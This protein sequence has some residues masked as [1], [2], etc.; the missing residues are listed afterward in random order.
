MIKGLLIDFGGTIDTDGIHWFRMFQMAYAQCGYDIPEDVLRQAYVYAERT[1]GKV[2]M[3]SPDM[4]MT[5][6]IRVK[7]GLQAGF[8]RGMGILLK[9]CC[10]GTGGVPCESCNQVHEIE[11]ILDCCMSK[12][13]YNIDNVSAPVLKELSS[14]YRLGLVSNF[15][16]NINAVLAEFGIDG[17]FSSVTESAVVG[18]RKPD[19]EIFRIAASSL[20]LTPAEC[21]A[22]GDS[23]DKD[24]IPAQTAGCR[25]VWLTAPAGGGAGVGAAGGG[26]GAGAGVAGGGAS[27]GWDAAECAPDW[28]I[29][30][31]RDLLTLEL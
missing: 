7:L 17:Y 23:A 21:V 25:T 6:T 18:V 22:V 3:I 1:L 27:A 29:S 28:R 19:P 26:A 12:V 24:I 31:F 9:G 8:L 5:D 11:R 2:R 16:G 15:Y 10:G 4:S 20:G 14:R 13:R 30:S